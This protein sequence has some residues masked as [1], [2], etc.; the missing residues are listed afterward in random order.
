MDRKSFDQIISHTRAF[1][2]FSTYPH[3]GTREMIYRYVCQKMGDI[4]PVA[5]SAA[6]RILRDRGA[7]TFDKKV[8]W[9]IAD[10]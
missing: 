9:F 7:I 8:W 10:R 1:F 2:V 4:P 6:L 3:G 5:V